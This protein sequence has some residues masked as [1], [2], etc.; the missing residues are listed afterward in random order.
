ME[1]R[2]YADCCHDQGDFMGA[3][4]ARRDEPVVRR[5]AGV[6]LLATFF[7]GSL[8]NYAI[9]VVLA[10]TSPGARVVRI[11]IKPGDE[12]TTVTP[13]RGGVLPVVLYSG[14]TFDAANVDAK[15]IRFGA[16]G[17]EAQP[18]R[19]SMED[20]DADGRIDL[21]S[22]FRM[23]QTGIECGHTMAVLRGR[24]YDGEDIEGRA[25]FRTAG[26]GS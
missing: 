1:M 4:N 18:M 12:P 16:T 2:G 21:I 25:V 5:Q 19:T 23:Q 6:A 15:S 11:D 24:T 14:A 22:M 7:L 20:V 3:C 9:P 8:V 10:D 17:T 26:C 13:G